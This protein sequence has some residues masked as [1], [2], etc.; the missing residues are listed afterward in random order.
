MLANM[1]VIMDSELVGAIL[2]DPRDQTDFI[3][4]FLGYAN[5]SLSNETHVLSISANN[6]VAS[7]LVLFDYYIYTYAL[8]LSPLKML[9]MSK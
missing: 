5:T 1:S 3:Y 6:Q 4:N 9:L 8:C 7:S 2:H